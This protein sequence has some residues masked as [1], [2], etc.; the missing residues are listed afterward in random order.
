MPT[1]ATV[2]SA[3]T[4]RIDRCMV[5]SEN[6]QLLTTL[7]GPRF[8]GNPLCNSC[9]QASV[10]RLFSDFLRAS[11]HAARS[12][13]CRDWAR[14]ALCVVDRVRRRGAAPA[15]GGARYGRRRSDR[16]PSGRCCPSRSPSRCS[17]RNGTPP[18]GHSDGGMADRGRRTTAGRGSP[19]RHRGKGTRAVAARQQ[20]RRAADA[21]RAAGLEPAV[22]TAIAEGRDAVPFDQ[23][24]PLDFATYDGSNQVVHPDFVATPDNLFTRPFH[25][26]ITPYPFGNPAYENPS[27]FESDPAQHVGPDRGRSQ[28]RRAAAGRLSV[29][30]RSGLGPGGRRALAL[31][32]TSHHR[33][34][35]A[36]DADA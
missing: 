16:A 25:L 34:H 13:S 20:H 30:S 1:S 35:R 36:P 3:A 8:R 14:V 7:S 17:T 10:E 2:A 28:S 19:D 27:F 4:G 9:V 12:I 32:P 6:N 11:A 33:E 24:I 21:G 5:T 15:G 31:L 22:F 18:K 29:R 26:A 23:I